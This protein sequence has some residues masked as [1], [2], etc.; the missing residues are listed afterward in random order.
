MQVFW[1]MFLACLITHEPATSYIQSHRYFRNIFA[2]LLIVV[3]LFVASYPEGEPQ[4]MAWSNKLYK[5]SL[6]IL[7]PDADIPRFYSGIGLELLSLGIV[8]SETAQHILS[9][10]FLLFLGK[11][12]FAVYLIH[13]TMLRVVLCWMLFGV[14]LPQDVRNQAG[15]IVAG[16]P[17]KMTGPVGQVVAVSV[18]FVLLYTLADRWTAY[19]DP[20]CLRWIAKLE[21]MV[22]VKGEKTVLP[23]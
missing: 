18:W 23:S 22:F 20:M 17:L 21:K 11:N 14:K 13:G 1:G 2:P 3:G 9:H 4:R 16:A 6:E 12:S 15:E 5:L 8:F 7:P 10:R 19:I